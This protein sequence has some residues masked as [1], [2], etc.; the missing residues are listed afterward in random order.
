MGRIESVAC[1][2]VQTVVHGR[3]G[4]ARSKPL[5]RILTLFATVFSFYELPLHKHRPHL[6]RDL[7]QTWQLDENDYI[8]SFT[9][10]EI[11][12]PEDMLHKLGDM[13]FSGSVRKPFHHFH[14]TVHANSSD[15]L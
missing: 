5:A 7:R 6:F 3:K 4:R 2:I 14:N 1:S 11:T 10:D 12:K 13:G 9:P 8:A 15:L